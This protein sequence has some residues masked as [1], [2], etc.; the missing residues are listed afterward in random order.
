MFKAIS[1]LL[2]GLQARVDQGGI[3]PSSPQSLRE[4]QGT[5]ACLLQREQVVLGQIGALLGWLT[6]PVRQAGLGRETIAVMADELAQRR[7]I[8]THLERR[9]LQQR[10]VLA[11]LADGRAPQRPMARAAGV[12]VPLGDMRWR[13]MLAT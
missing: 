2:W 4:A 7:A 9:I 12:V 11:G 8:L 6:D 13:R 3:A 1:R 10:Q 5:L